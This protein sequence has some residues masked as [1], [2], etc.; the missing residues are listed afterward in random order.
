MVDDVSRVLLSSASRW[1]VNGLSIHSSDLPLPLKPSST[2]SSLQFSSSTMLRHFT[3]GPV[4]HIFLES[5][6]SDNTHCLQATFHSTSWP[7]YTMRYYPSFDIFWYMTSVL[8]RLRY[9]ENVCNGPG[10]ARHG[11]P[12]SRA[13][14]CPGRACP[15]RACPDRRPRAPPDLPI[16]RLVCR[17]S[18]QLG[19]GPG[20]R[21]H[22]QLPGRAGR[23]PAAHRGWKACKL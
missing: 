11:A 21:R 22:P 23:P 1:A 9:I 8:T 2:C 10:P 18:C 12:P 7:T 13:C 14:S 16:R 3:R 19:Q 17:N 6:Y 4:K 5:I 15:L 20:A